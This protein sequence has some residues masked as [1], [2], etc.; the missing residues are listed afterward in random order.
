MSTANEKI[1]ELKEALVNAKYKEEDINKVMEAANF[2][3]VKHAN[4]LRKSG[5]PYVIHPISTSIILIDWD[6]DV[7]TIIAGVLHDVLEDTETEEYEIE[8]KFG[9]EV[10]T[11]VKYVTKVSLFSKKNRTLQKEKS[12]IEKDYTIQVFLSMSNDLRA[13]IIKLADRYH[14]MTTIKYL[15][16]H[17]QKRIA[18]ETIEI[19]AKIA[20]RLGMYNIKTD[21]LDMSFSVLNP[22]SY[23]STKDKIEEI[24]EKNSSDWS[25]MT[26]RIRDILSSYSINFQIKNRLKGIHSTWEKEQKGYDVIDIHDIYAIRIIVDNVLDCYKVLGL[27]HLNFNYLKNTFKDY[28]SSP[29]LNLY[30]SIHTTILKNETLLE[31]Q[32]RTN[33]MDLVA[34]HG[35]AAHWRYKDINANKTITN[36]IEDNNMIHEFLRSPSKNLEEIKKF[37]NDV[38]FEVF[39]LNNENKFIV[40]N[41][42]KAI[43]VAVRYDKN[44]VDKLQSVY[45]NGEK[46]PFYTVLNPGDTIK[47]NYAINP[48]IGPSWLKFSN[49]Q[50]TRETIKEIIDVQEHYKLVNAEDFIKRIKERLDDKFVGYDKMLIFLKK[51]LNVDSLEAF[52]DI[53]PNEVYN[54]VDLINVFDKRKNIAKIALANL[55][56]KYT[57]W[58]MNQMYLM[59]IEGVVFDSISF[60]NCC[61]K[62]PYMNIAGKIIK[63]NILEVHNHD[64]VQLKIAK[65]KQKIYPLN[66]D[67]KQLEKFPRTFKLTS[68]FEAVWIPTIG[69]IITKNFNRFKLSICEL[70][71]KRKKVENTCEVEFILYVSNISSVNNCFKKIAEEINIIKTPKY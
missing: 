59:P 28:I 30:Q 52:L 19:Y 63:N 25:E 66:W 27:I 11:L 68:S 31:I 41:K 22:Y 48:T 17:K 56:K 38:V 64:C 35:L 16:E 53:V 67:V 9:L 34:S 65:H 21:L 10:L 4:Q 57:K 12:E 23:N 49:N 20:G 2:A 40:N 44:N 62:V 58:R 8:E 61:N 54:D 5:E 24:I 51:R 3:A 47:F 39:L 60:P 29:K 1:Q 33:E 15:P 55:N 14:N 70:K 42:S 37:T 46:M 7:N 36:I 18:Q 43:D 26:K 45:I 6:M 13:M 71:I 50:Y 69:N 32:I